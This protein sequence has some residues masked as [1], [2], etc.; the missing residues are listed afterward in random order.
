MTRFARFAVI[1]IATLTLGLAAA[2]AQT[3]AASAGPESK[4]SAQLTAAATLG[5]TSASSFGGE[6]DYRLMEDWEGFFE[7]GR[8]RNVTSSATEAR[9]NVISRQL[10]VTLSP[11]QKATYYDIGLKY[12]L[13]PYGMWHPYVALGF[14][15]A[16]VTTRTALSGVNPEQEVQLGFD[17]DSSVTKP[18]VMIG[19]GAQVPFRNRYFVDGSYR[20]GRIF[21]R[22]GVIEDDTGMSTQRVQ[23]GVGIRF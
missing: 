10:N 6:V 12:R 20:Y 5:H 18:F 21:A 8:L 23:V 11:I 22:T 7:F 17:L 14:G 2:H 1:F 3:P 9:A 13:L 16:T 19:G 15:A 4:F